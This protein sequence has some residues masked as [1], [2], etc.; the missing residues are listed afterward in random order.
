[1]R[2]EERGQAGEEGPRAGLQ[3]EQVAEAAPSPVMQEAGEILGAFA[4][5]AARAVG[6]SLGRQ[7]IRGVMGSIFGGGGRRR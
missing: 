2:R 6:S 4:T 5:S 1:M 7:I 3:Q